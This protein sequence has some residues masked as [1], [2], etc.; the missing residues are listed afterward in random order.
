MSRKPARASDFLK[1]LSLDTP[2][3]EPAS[4]PIASVPD[5]EPAKRG[6]PRKESG[7][8]AGLKHIGGYLQDES[9]E[10]FALLKIRTKLG[11]DELLARAIDELWRVESAKRSFG[12]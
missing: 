5:S 12:N 4:S 3:A 11:N 2:A 9:V 7:S 6:R 8:R 1:S 10:R